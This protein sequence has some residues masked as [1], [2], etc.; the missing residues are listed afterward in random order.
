MHRRN[1][2][3]S[4]RPCVLHTGPTFGQADSQKCRLEC[5]TLSFSANIVRYVLCWCVCV[6]CIKYKQ[7][8]GKCTVKKLVVR[9]RDRKRNTNDWVSFSMSERNQNGN[10]KKSKHLNAVLFSNQ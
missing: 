8:E 9:H 4:V 7:N 2:K 5:N 10:R 3:K 1:E 6:Q